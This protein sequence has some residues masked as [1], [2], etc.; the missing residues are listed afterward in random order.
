MSRGVV[1]VY[2]SRLGG[3][4]RRDQKVMLD[5]DARAIAKLKGYDFGGHHETA[6]DYSVP[7]FFVPDDTLLQDEALSLGI[8]CVQD[9][10][11]GVVPYPFVK[12]KAIPHQLV[13]S[14]AQQPHGWSSSFAEKIREWALPGYTAFS[15]HDA[16]IAATRMLNRGPV[17]LKQPLCASGEGQALIT[18]EHE[19]NSFLERLDAEE[20]ATYGLVLEENLREVR[21]LSVGHTAL[22]SLSISYHGTQRRVQDNAGRATYGGSDLVFVRGAWDALEALAMTPEVRAGVAQAKLYDKWMS[23]Y[24]GFMASRRNYDVAQGIDA[25]GQRRSGVLESSW[26][27]GGASSA[28]LAALAAFARDP[29]L[30]IVE[31]STVEEFGSDRKPPANA[32]IHFAGEDPQLGPLL[33]YTVVRGK[34]VRGESL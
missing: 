21:T 22:G 10:Y 29:A 11:G 5:V 15:A 8:R 18:T 7:V 34:T 19:F 6:R 17:R 13:D 14:N 31:A 9:L 33:R 30:A 1:L 16:R 4:L 23:E 32:L 20:I 3:R 2:F 12:T 28:E 27:A 24:P 26:R 25:D